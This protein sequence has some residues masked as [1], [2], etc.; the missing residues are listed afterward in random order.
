MSQKLINDWRAPHITSEWGVLWRVRRGLKKDKSGHPAIIPPSVPPQ[1]VLD[2]HCFLFHSL[3]L[4]FFTLSR[5]WPAGLISKKPNSPFD[6]LLS[7]N[8][9]RGGGWR[10][11]LEAYLEADSIGSRSIEKCWNWGLTNQSKVYLL[12][13][14]SVTAH[15]FFGN[16]YPNGN[17]IRALVPEMTLPPL[18]YLSAV[19]YAWASC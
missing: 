19:N 5:C 15:H 9:Y 8:S 13:L 3:P 16:H 18:W 6:H 11:K 10:K 14:T 4:H 12:N 7:R 1:Q 2:P 17:Q